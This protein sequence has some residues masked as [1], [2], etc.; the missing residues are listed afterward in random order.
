VKEFCRILALLWE[1][2][3]QFGRIRK[4]LAE[5]STVRNLVTVL[6]LAYRIGVIEKCCLMV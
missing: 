3:L 1:Y 2:Y 5:Y 4:C 6:G